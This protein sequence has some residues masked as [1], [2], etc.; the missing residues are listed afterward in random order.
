MNDPDLTYAQVNLNDALDDVKLPKK[1]SCGDT[2]LDHY[3][4]S[5]NL[6]RAIKSENLHATGMFD[7]SQQ[8]IG[9]M[10][11]GFATLDKARV[12]TFKGNQPP[13]LP[14][15]K[16]IMIAVDQDHQG[17]GLGT[18]LMLEAF[19]KAATVHKTIPLKGVYLDAAPGKESFYSEMF[20]FTA[21]EG[22][23]PAGSTPMF[24][25]IE[26]VIAALSEADDSE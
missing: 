17:R 18:D 1:F 22:P 16:V 13:Q 19:T 21:L 10:T 8:F 24:I 6:K 26:D 9:F 25:P 12:K 7:E 11:V 2:L 5:G 15:A 20:G 4:T 3:V 14:V 23:G